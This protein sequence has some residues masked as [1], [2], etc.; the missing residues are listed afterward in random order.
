VCVCVCSLV[1]C[2]H[3]FERTAYCRRRWQWPYF[4]LWGFLQ[5]YRKII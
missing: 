1:D 5:D 4:F 3:R 2:Y